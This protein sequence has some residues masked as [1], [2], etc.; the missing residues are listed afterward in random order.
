LRFEEKRSVASTPESGREKSWLGWWSENRSGPCGHC[1]RSESPGVVFLFH[2]ELGI[3]LPPTLLI[4]V[5]CP[6][7]CTYTMNKVAETL[8]LFYIFT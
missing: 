2:R 7:F 1:R 8:L 4:Y 5:Q 3:T 6:L